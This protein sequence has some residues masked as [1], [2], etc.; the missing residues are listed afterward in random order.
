MATPQDL[1]RQIL[2]QS[3]LLIRESQRSEHFRQALNHL[4][5]WLQ[6]VS[7]QSPGTIAEPK[8]HPHRGASHEQHPDV[9]ADLR[10]I[11]Q[12]AVLKIEAC[13]FALERN[14]FYR[15]HNRIDE[16]KPWYDRLITRAKDLPRCILWMVRL[17]M[18]ALPDAALN[19]VRACYQNLADAAA[20]MLASEPGVPDDR[21]AAMDL[22]AES[23]SALMVCFSRHTKSGM[24]QDQFDA[25]TW[26]KEHAA[27]SGIFIERF[28]SREHRADPA[29][30]PDLSARIAAAGQALAAKSGPSA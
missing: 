2:N 14:N 10:V 30:A 4:A 1:I 29:G 21:R 17:D 12:R 7:Y 9:P 25:W 28:M 27:Q 22:L 20:L 3:E 19:E 15:Q 5:Q 23:Q 8:L 6:E 11:Q 24:D 26:V 18:I 13:Q 16:F